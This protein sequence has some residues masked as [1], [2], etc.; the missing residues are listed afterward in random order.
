MGYDLTIGEL[1][2]D[3]NYYGLES[4]ISLSV[5]GCKLDNA[6]AYG[7]PT[8]YTNSR[9]PSYTSW[10]D[11]MDFLGLKDLMNY[12]I[13]KHPGCVPLT[14]DHKKVIDEAHAKFYAKYPNAKAGYAPNEND[15]ESWPEE[16]GYAT[17]LEWLKFWVD[18]ALENC[19]VPVFA[20]S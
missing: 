6:P 10:G 7:E 1:K 13:A 18:W 8:D 12:L 17:R 2:I 3:I 15:D 14:V 19:K 16:N 20:N 5:E 9:W 11:A 4:Y